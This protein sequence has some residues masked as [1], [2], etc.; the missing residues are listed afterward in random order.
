MYRYGYQDRLLDSNLV[1]MLMIINYF[2][3][4]IDN[5]RIQSKGGT[6][7]SFETQFRAATYDTES[8]A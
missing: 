6:I 5:F 2:A 3:D 7:T 8:V 4:E 1:I